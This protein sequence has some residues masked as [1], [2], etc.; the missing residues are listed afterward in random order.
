MLRPTALALAWACRAN[1]LYRLSTRFGWWEQALAAATRA[2]YHATAAGGVT[3]RAAA[4]LA[5]C[6]THLQAACL[7]PFRASAGLA[8]ASAGLLVG[9]AVAPG[10]LRALLL[11]AHGLLVAASARRSDGA[12]L[13]I[14]TLLAEGAT[15]AVLCGRARPYAR[16]PV[17]VEVALLAD[18]GAAVVG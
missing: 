17:S 2:L 9:A 16:L 10:R 4:A 6:A 13:V 15:G 8:A 12:T 7:V 18:G 11:L 5:L 1:L 3:P 14:A